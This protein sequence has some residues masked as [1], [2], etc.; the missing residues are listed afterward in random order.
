MKQRNGIFLPN[1]QRN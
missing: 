1:L